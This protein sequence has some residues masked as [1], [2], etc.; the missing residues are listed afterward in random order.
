MAKWFNISEHYRFKLRQQLAEGRCDRNVYGGRLYL[1]FPTYKDFFF[2]VSPP[3]RLWI[4][5]PYPFKD[6]PAYS[7]EVK[8]ADF[9]CNFN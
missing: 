5:L 4:D 3:D 2:H 1:V 9:L 8:A 7:L 6:G